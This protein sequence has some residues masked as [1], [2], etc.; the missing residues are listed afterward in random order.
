M[1]IIIKSG[2][3]WAVTTTT[4]GDRGDRFGLR[5]RVSRLEEKERGDRGRKGPPASLYLAFAMLGGLARQ[6]YCAIACG[7]AR[8]A[9]E[10][11]IVAMAANVAGLMRHM[12]W[13]GTMPGGLVW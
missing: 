4:A 6:A 12:Q 7:A 5:R 10:T 11:T 13:H 3:V 1:Q 8:Y 9:S 2:E